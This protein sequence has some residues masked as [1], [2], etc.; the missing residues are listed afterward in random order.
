MVM[1]KYTIFMMNDRF[2]Y[3]MTLVNNALSMFCTRRP[4]DRY[5]SRLDIN[6]FLQY[7]NNIHPMQYLVL[8]IFPHWKRC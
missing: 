1:N 6:W 7:L 5:F 2:V 8:Q 4:F 3:G